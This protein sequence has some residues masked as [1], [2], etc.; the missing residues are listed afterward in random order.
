MISEILIG[1]ILVVLIARMA[2]T[3]EFWS[4][5]RNVLR[6]II[7]VFETLLCIALGIA[8]GI[9]CLLIPGPNLITG[10]SVVSGFVYDVESDGF[11]SG[12]TTFKVRASKDTA[13][14]EGTSHT[15]CLDKD[16]PY[17]DL[18]VKAGEDH[19]K[20]VSVVREKG[21]YWANIFQCGQKVTVKGK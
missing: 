6:V 20:E 14:N 19:D 16:S 2:G 17:T 15:Y 5:H 18:V 12:K 13:T 8:L 11:I 7:G 3:T 4:D 10:T 9:G 1:A 21:I